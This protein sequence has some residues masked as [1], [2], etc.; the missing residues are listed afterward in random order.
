[1]ATQQKVW[2]AWHSRRLQLTGVWC[3]ALGALVAGCGGST[4]I[5][6]SARTASTATALTRTTPPARGDISSFTWDITYG[7]P[8]SLD[9]IKGGYFTEA[10]VMSNMCDQLFWT[11]PTT[12]K[13]IPDIATSVSR[14]ND[15]TYVYTIRRGVK[16]WDG[17]ALTAEDVAYSLLRNTIPSLG[18]VEAPIFA[19]VKRIYVSAPYQVTVTLTRPDEL[20]GEEMAAEPMGTIAEAAYM[21]RE[22]SAYGTASGGVMCS[23]PFRLVKWTPGTSIVLARNPNYWNKSLIPKAAQ[24]VFRF[25]SDTSAVT[26]GLESGTFDGA[27]EVPTSSIPELKASGAG[28]LYMGPSSQEYYL[29]PVGGLLRSTDIRRALSLVIDRAGIAKT[30]FDGAALPIASWSPPAVWGYDRSAFAAEAAAVPGNTVNTA[31][32]KKLVAAAGSPTGPIPLGI[33]AGS[34]Q[35]VEMATIVQQEAHQVGLNVT[36]RSLAP[37]TYGNLY[38]QAGARAGLAGFFQ[39][40]YFNI[41][42]PVDEGIFWMLPRSVSYANFLNY[43]NPIVDTDFTKAWQTYNPDLRATYYLAAEKQYLEDADSIPVVAPY[44]L[45]FVGK[46]ITG[47]TTAFP[48]YYEYPWAATVG[49]AQ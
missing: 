32:A 26:T 23:G 12:G 39:A 34:Q 3:A 49:A 31:L 14:P 11:D 46:R 40:N 5:S 48:A 6:Q 33:E 44:E 9:Y 16:F 20:F 41:P 2:T 30:V 38:F 45:T 8:T 1:M 28:H 29:T 43:T 37:T 4:A 10:A 19:H 24:V 42:D 17:H 36:I 21:K 15:E 18:S 47:M 22:G 27:Y 7:E 25:V 35:Q 13:P